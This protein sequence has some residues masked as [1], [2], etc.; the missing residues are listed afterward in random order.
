M[1]SKRRKFSRE[2]K[3]EAVRLITEKGY[4][5]AQVGRD[6]ELRPDMLRR[7]KKQFAD[8]PAGAFYVCLEGRIKLSQLT[9]E[10]NQ[11]TMH[12][13]GP[14]EA[15]GI[16]AVLRGIRFPVTAQAVEDSLVLAWKDS[17]IK[18]WL[19][20]EPQI[21]LNSIR[22]LSSYIENF[23]DRI[24]ELSTERVERRLARTLLRLVQQTGQKEASGIRINVHL[25]RQDIA[26]MAGTTLYTVSRTLRKWESEGLV[27]CSGPQILIKQPHQLVGVADDLPPTS[28]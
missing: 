8:D 7:W 12:L 20:D 25:S 17:A 2:F 18:R 11:V 5:I 14:G 21:A 24:K 26:E 3:L 27:D 28:S 1:G 10:G 13:P 23:Q 4:S 6:L 19:Q 15:F 16:I 9:P 22:I